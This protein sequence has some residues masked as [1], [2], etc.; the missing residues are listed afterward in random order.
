MVKHIV[1]WKLKDFAEGASKKENV[2]KIKS[3][4]EGL[5]SK[6]KE[7]K[8]LEVGISTSDAADFYDMVL[9]SEFKDMRDME[10]YRKHPEHVKAAEFIGKVQLERKVVDYIV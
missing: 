1:M 5:K 3:S 7:V 2:L 8:Y 4:L 9:I 10:S 6:I